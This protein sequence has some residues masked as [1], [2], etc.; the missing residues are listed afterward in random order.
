MTASGA[1]SA[2]VLR[3]LPPSLRPDSVPASYA[4]VKV[5]LTEI[6]RRFEKVIE[7]KG[8]IHHHIKRGVTRLMVDIIKR[9]K[10][11]IQLDSKVPG[12][13]NCFNVDLHI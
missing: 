1:S 10:Q 8:T 12:Y 2:P 13:H 11:D 5:H 4:A 9:F 6:R 7:E 3:H